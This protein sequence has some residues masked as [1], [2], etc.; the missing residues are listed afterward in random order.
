MSTYDESQWARQYL[1]SRETRVTKPFVFKPEHIPWI[2][3]GVGLAILLP[4]A[5]HLRTPGRQAKRK[6]KKY[7]PDIYRDV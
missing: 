3:G 5:K 7:T 2:V 1:D 4:V 6:R